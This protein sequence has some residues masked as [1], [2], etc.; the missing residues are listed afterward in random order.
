[1]LAHMMVIEYASSSGNDWFVVPLTLPVG[2]INRVDSLVVTDSF[3]VR[4]LLKPIGT[5]G[6]VARNFSLWQHANVRR[7]GA[8]HMP[9]LQAHMFF[10]APAIG[11][12][13][14]S[15]ALA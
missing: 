6:T 15:A 9:G 10:L 13:M 3:G 11:H 14:E 7:P 2:S 8:E 1:D 4:T 12:V 5:W